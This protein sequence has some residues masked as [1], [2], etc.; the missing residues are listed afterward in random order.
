MGCQK[1]GQ[2][3]PD[4]NLVSEL[5]RAL[6][7][8]MQRNKPLSCKSQYF[9]LKALSVP[10]LRVTSNSSAE[11]C[12]R[13]SASLFTTLGTFTFCRRLPASENCT[14]VTSPGVPVDAE[15]VIKCGFFSIH[16]K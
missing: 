14:T 13:H 15:A 8:Q 12:L 10:E 11:S 2:P 9:P 1:L 6:S 5:N 3:V 7:Q 16:K 4:S